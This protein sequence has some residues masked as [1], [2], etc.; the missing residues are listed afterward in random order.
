MQIRRLHPHFGRSAQWSRGGQGLGQAGAE[1]VTADAA[2]SK[3]A[4]GLLAPTNKNELK[5]NNAF[6]GRRNPATGAAYMT[7]G[8]LRTD[9][10]DLLIRARPTLN[11]NEQHGAL[12]PGPWI[13]V[14]RHR[15]GSGLR[16]AEHRMGVTR[17]QTLAIAKPLHR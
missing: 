15:L 3:I 4:A 16:L 2:I 9:V 12:R 11:T 7:R 6:V 5:S 14:R 10:W 1:V 8:S 13:L 17:D